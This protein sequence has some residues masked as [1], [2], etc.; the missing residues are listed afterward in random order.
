MAGSSSKEVSRSWWHIALSVLQQSFEFIE[1]KPEGFSSG[2]KTNQAG[3]WLVGQRRKR[4]E[5]HK[6]REFSLWQQLRGQRVPSHG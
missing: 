1:V 5:E 4:A 6:L 3:S 2:G